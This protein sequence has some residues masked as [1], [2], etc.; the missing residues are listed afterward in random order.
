VPENYLNPKVSVDNTAD[1]GRGLFAKEKIEKGELIEETK[2]IQILTKA[3]LATM[4]KIWRQLCYEISDQEEICPQD[5]N[6][7]GPGFL[8]NHSCE[9]NCGSTSGDFGMVAMRDIEAGEELTYD[10]AMTDAGNYEMKCNCGTRSC[11]HFIR[12]SDWQIPELQEKYKGYFQ[13]NI[14]DK[15]DSLN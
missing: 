13:K 9:P 6:N 7:P 15:I 12:G 4:P 2:D 5:I 10:Y 1:K 3:E 14:Q 11:R 8:I